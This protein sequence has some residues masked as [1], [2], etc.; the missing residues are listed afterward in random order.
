MLGTQKE[1]SIDAIIASHVDEL[2]VVAKALLERLIKRRSES[3]LEVEV[4]LCR[5]TACK[6]TSSKSGNVQN[7]ELRL[8]EAKVKP[9]VSANHYERLKAYCISKAMD[10]NIT[11]STT[12]DVVAHNWR[13]TYTAEPDDNEPTR[14]ISR[15][16]KNRV[17]VSD[18]LV[19]FA[20]YN[21]RFSVSTE[22][23][24]SLPKPGT[25]P[26]VGYT[27]LKERT[28]IVDGLFRYDMTRVVESNGATS[29]E[30]EI[31]GVFTQPETQLT[32]AWVMELLTKA[33]TLAI[34]LNNSSH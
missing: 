22:T 5:F 20:P 21:I 28:S 30:V 13:Y 27:R 1:E 18:I 8:V 24:G 12:R 26:E 7:D 3:S 10:G 11:H 15:V 23:S 33:L 16:K 6:D 29:Y 14:C 34:I 19:P 9:G 25:A 17:F 32:E 4:R 2:K 31:E